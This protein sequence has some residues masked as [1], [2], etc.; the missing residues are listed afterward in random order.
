V[1]PPEVKEIK[2]SILYY[3]LKEF[4][5]HI[6]SD[7]NFEVQNRERIFD[8]L[9]EK[10]ILTLDYKPL[11]LRIVTSISDGEINLLHHTNGSDHVLTDKGNLI[12]LAWSKDYGEINK[13][14]IDNRDDKIPI[15]KK[16]KFFI[17]CGERDTESEIGDFL[18]EKLS[19]NRDVRVYWW[20][21]KYPN[22]FLPF[23]LADQIRKEIESSDY[24][25]GILHKRE[26][27]GNGQYT[28][29][30]SVQDEMKWA[31]EDEIP[32]LL[33]RDE[34]VAI[35]GMILPNYVVKKVSKSSEIFSYI[36]DLI[37]QTFCIFR[38][39]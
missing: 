27:L 18:Y 12:C 11:F 39:N 19:E 1:L 7:G 4:Q 37:K 32:R 36:K 10:G 26:K 33:L 14:K 15:T 23:T 5:N 20:K 35:E 30:P 38:D 22:P 9:V 34:D 21:S 8:S 25:I 29:S 24:F 13:I 3:I 16:C 2:G 31:I 17:S 28:S 6:K